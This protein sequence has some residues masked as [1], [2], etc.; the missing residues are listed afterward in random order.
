[1][2][3]RRSRGLPLTMFTA[4]KPFVGHID[5]IQRNA[6]RS[7]TQL[8]PRPRILLFG[9]EEGTRTV[10]SEFGVEH[11]SDVGRS[12][13]GTPLISSLFEGAEA[14][15]GPVL[16]YVNCDIVLLDD[17][18][19]SIERIGFRRFLA[20]GRR[21]DV[22]V[23]EQIDFENGGWRQQLRAQAR[24]EGRLHEATGID[25]FVF[26]RGLLTPLPPFVVG[27]A[28]WDNAMILAARQRRI[29]VVDLTA[30]VTA[31]HQNHDYAHVEGG[32]DGAFAGP[33]ARLNLEL[34][35]GPEKVMTIEDATWVLTPGGIRSAI[36]AEH[37]R[38]R[39]AAQSALRPLLYRVL[40]PALRVGSALER[41]AASHRAR[42]GG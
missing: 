19:P 27:R 5:L 12:E 36:D 21:W 37:L 7:W 14:R 42:A 17:F 1:M 23:A 13:Q 3:A 38:R 39:L 8:S 11:V 18:V 22:D 31:V 34:M 28:G 40:R 20:V 15:S 30:R 10:A 6:I 24:S 2:G 4:P 9:N 33:E 41:R 35:G 29:P 25:Y 26:S 16:A 32:M